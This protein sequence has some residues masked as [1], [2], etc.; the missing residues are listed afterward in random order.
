[1]E[2]KNI[3]PRPREIREC[4]ECKNSCI[5]KF[6]DDELKDCVNF[7]PKRISAEE[8]YLRKIFFSKGVKKL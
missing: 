7:I 6:T 8:K 1:M 5:G 3:F 2:R 4:G